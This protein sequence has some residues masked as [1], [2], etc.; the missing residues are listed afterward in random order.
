MLRNRYARRAVL[1]LAFLISVLALGAR[2]AYAS[3]FRFGTMYW[4][5]DLTYFNPANPTEIKIRIYIEAGMRWGY[6]FPVAPNA[7]QLGPVGSTN[8]SLACAGAVL[9]PNQTTAAGSCPPLNAFITPTGSSNA[10]LAF[11]KAVRVV[12]ANFWLPGHAP[13]D[14]PAVVSTQIG[15][16]GFPFYAKVTQIVPTADTAYVQ[17]TIDILIQQSAATAASPLVV[18]WQD[19]CRLTQILDNNVNNWRIETSINAANGITRS[20]RSVSLP[21]IQVT[22]GVDNT[23]ALPTT[24]FDNA[25]VGFR[26]PT[27]TESQLATAQPASPSTFSLNRTTG[28][29]TFK[30]RTTGLYAVQFKIGAYPAGSNPVI[31]QPLNE[32]PIDLLFQAVAGSSQAST[33]SL[34]TGDGATTYVATVP[35]AFSYQVKA[36]LSPAD[37]T[38]T[39]TLNPGPLPAGATFTQGTTNGGATV[40]GTFNWT[41]TVTSTPSLVC[42]QATATRSQVFI[43]QSQNQL[44]VTTNLNPLETQLTAFPAEGHGGGPLVM[45]AKLVRQ[46][47]QAPLPNRGINFT[48]SDPLN[49]PWVADCP[50]AFTDS[51][52]VA[53][54]V[55][56]TTRTVTAG[57]FVA[58]F[59]AIANELVTSS[60][61]GGAVVIRTATTSLNAPTT[62]AAP[63]NSFGYPVTVSAV[64]NR[65]DTDGGLF[66]PPGQVVR[67]TLTDPNGTQTVLNGAVAGN[68]GVATVTF[69]ADVAPV[70]GNYTVSAY[71]EGNDLLL[72]DVTSPATTFTLGQRLKLTPELATGGAN[73]PTALRARLTLDP[74]GTPVAGKV[75]AF[76]FGATT[77][78]AVTDA[79]GWAQVLGTFP[80]VGTTTFSASFTPAAGTNELNGQALQAKEIVTGTVNITPA[81]PTVVNTT[82]FAGTS[83]TDGTLSAQLLSGGL[84]LANM[85]LTFSVDGVAVGTVATSNDGR[86]SVTVTPTKSEAGQY[87]VAF[88]GVANVYLAS[89]STS[90]YVVANA[91]STTTISC[92]APQTFSGAP[93]TPCTATVSGPGGLSESVV[94]SYTNNLNA[95]TA[96][97]TAAFAGDASHDASD[98][99]TTFA[100]GQ[101]ESTTVVTCDTSPLT[102]DGSAQTPCTATASGNG[103]LNAL[104]TVSY[105]NNVN[106]GTASATASFAGDANHSGSDGAATFQI[107]RALSTTTVVCPAAPAT[108]TGAAQMPCTATASGPGGLNA[109]V[110]VTYS[111][112]V[113]AGTADA[114][115][116]F[117]GDANHSGS[118]GSATFTIGAAASTAAV[119]CTTGS[120]F[121]GTA[122]TPCAATATGDGGLSEALTVSYSNNINAGTATATASFAGDTNHTASNGSATFT[123]DAAASTVAVTCTA[124]SIYSGTAQT[125]C[126]ATVTGDGGLNAP[127]TVSYGNNINAGTAT[128]AASFAG[129]A[130]HIASSGSAS[131]TIGAAGSTVTVSC[132]AAVTYTGAAQTPCS[133]QATGVGGLSQPVAVTYAANTAAGTALANATFAGDANHT[134]NSGAATFAINRAAAVVTWGAPASINQGTPLGA[135]QLN[136]T[137]PVPGTFSY[138]PAAGTVLAPGT[139]TLSV[140]FTPADAANY[141]PATA[142]VSITVNATSNVNVG[143]GQTVTFT[144]G[145]VRGNLT[146][147]AGGAVILANGASVSGNL[148]ANGG[149]VTMSNATVHGNLQVTNGHFALGAGAVVTGNF[150]VTGSAAGAGASTMC[151]ATVQGNVSVTASAAAVTIGNPGAACQG[152]VITGQLQ[153]TSNT[154]GTQV[155]GNAIDKNMQCSSNAPISGGSNTAKQKQ[156]QCSGF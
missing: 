58:T 107:G 38:A 31:A 97:A 70:S 52:G 73:L 50:T 55:V 72:G 59:N 8:P 36:T 90:A 19:C 126:A 30:P 62:P 78:Q 15:V 98:A 150:Q 25:V 142:S 46:L 154:G 42:Y 44:C 132:P 14:V 129:D 21:I 40:T 112:N 152:N 121:T 28:V 127:L 114:S 134:G 117:A 20:P 124:G 91:A 147:A 61:G 80:T 155:F 108:Y 23:I 92:T 137:A 69:P 56:Q 131:F 83:W 3:H 41:P 125:P 43:A 136:A 101:A 93:L 16:T 153:L 22:S 2:P 86:A 130:N 106:A 17:S 143:P 149:S 103:G 26:M 140:T 32:T 4:E 66:P 99:S 111:N 123:I 9:T 27:T 35:Q 57:E 135:A 109:A 94:V 48:W 133:A 110:D 146:V 37:P 104:L 39:V 63:F 151:G 33:L 71:F 113:N 76:T 51:T 138:T 68:Q 139:A 18:T 148:Q 64:L 49:A 156:G 10:Y 82:A 53:T 65:I 60:Q 74:Q 45:K 88:A 6:P 79:T 87:S 102:F 67:F 12:G 24:V 75:V 13:Q 141:S 95:G 105:S 145:T 100:I 96:T 7:S 11:N 119:S 85:P 144:G 128:A 1:T 116:S 122:Q 115:A 77:L 54:C 81:A 34:A 5:R 118:D 89:A 29:V 47:D 84:P 120:V